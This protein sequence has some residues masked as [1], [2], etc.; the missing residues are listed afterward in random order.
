MLRPRGVSRRAEGRIGDNC[1][2][3]QQ[4][5]VTTC[6]NFPRNSESAARSLRHEYLTRKYVISTG[7]HSKRININGTK[8]SLLLNPER[9]AGQRLLENAAASGL[10]LPGRALQEPP[11]QQLA[12]PC[13]SPSGRIWGTWGGGAPDNLHLRLICL[14]ADRARGGAGEP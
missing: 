10:T 6:S 9:T 3:Q 11:E 13:S 7:P 14:E 1:Q 8:P 5:L 4:Q 2:Q 12:L